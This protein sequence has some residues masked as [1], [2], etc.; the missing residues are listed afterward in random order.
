MGPLPEANRCNKHILV[1]PNGIHEAFPTPNQKASTVTKVLVDGVLNRFRP[2]V[3]L[4]SD[5]GANFARKHIDVEG[6]QLMGIT[7]TRTTAYQHYRDEEV[8][9]QNRTLQEMS[10]AFCNKH[11]ND[12]D[13]G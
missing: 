2:P 3:V 13:Y 5:Q 7:K 4:H 12:R 11:D 6:L 8:E 1:L 9:R 10:V